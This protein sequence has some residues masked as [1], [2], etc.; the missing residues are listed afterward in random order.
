MFNAPL[1]LACCSSG[2]MPPSPEQIPVPARSAPVAIAS[3]ASSD[4]APKL[5]SETNSGIS[6]FKGLAALGPI[7]NSVLTGSVSISG[8]RANCATS[9]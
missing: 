9:N 5:I 4:K 1:L 7:T 8:L 6:S 2:N 3:L